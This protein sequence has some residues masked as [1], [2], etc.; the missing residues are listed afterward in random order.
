MGSSRSSLSVGG[1]RHIDRSEIDQ[2]MQMNR[3]KDITKSLPFNFPPPP[4]H[5]G[6][7]HGG[8][9]AEYK[10]Y[11]RKKAIAEEWENALVAYKLRHRQGDQAAMQSIVARLKEKLAGAG[12][13]GKVGQETN[14]RASRGP[15]TRLSG[16][17]E[18]I[19]ALAT[20]GAIAPVRSVAH[21]SV[22]MSRMSSQYGA[23]NAN[24]LK[25]QLEA[26]Q[27]ALE[28]ESNADF[29]KPQHT[30]KPAGSTL[31][32]RTAAEL[33]DTYSSLDAWAGKSRATAI[34]EDEEPVDAY[35]DVIPYEAVPL[36]CSF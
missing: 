22:R 17:I 24:D 7:F 16:I 21:R 14:P 25:A 1:S 8:S 20:G 27:A 30:R 12:P 2:I 11:M 36:S 34:E 3:S 9:E 35:D 19:K 31:P 5:P 29:S 32:G 26:E 10:E 23:I 18:D 13:V 15:S 28:A 33:T 6:D 4:Q